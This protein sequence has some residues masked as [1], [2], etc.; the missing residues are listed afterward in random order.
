MGEEDEAP[1]NRPFQKGT[2]PLESWAE[3]VVETAA[4]GVAAARGVAG[5]K[6]LFSAGSGDVVG[7]GLISAC[8]DEA[9]LKIRFQNGSA[10]L[11]SLTGGV[12]VVLVKASAGGV[13]TPPE[14]GC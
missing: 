11:G 8:L 13:L 6:A 2:A 10:L 14:L 12:G 3:G 9:P 1:L 4:L 7:P 5:G